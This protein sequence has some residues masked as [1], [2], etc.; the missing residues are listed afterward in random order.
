MVEGLRSDVLYHPVGDLVVDMVHEPLGKRR[1]DDHD[2]NFAKDRKQSVKIH[3]A[4][5]QDQVDTLSHQDRRVKGGCH[6]H[7]SQDQGENYQPFVASNI[8]QDPL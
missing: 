5:T 3:I 6:G 8:V 4:G 2:R 1:N 7:G